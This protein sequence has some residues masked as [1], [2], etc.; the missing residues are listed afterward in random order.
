MKKFG[1]FFASAL[2]AFS[3]FIH[4]VFA[5]ESD[6]TIYFFGRNDCA[7]C[8]EEKAF[9][10]EYLPTVQGVTYEYFN[11][12]E[13]DTAKALYEK[14]LAKHELSHVTPVTVIGDMVLQGFDTKETTGETMKSAVARARAS[15]IRSLDDH[16]ARA[17]KQSDSFKGAGCDENGTECGTLTNPNMYMFNLPVIGVVDFKSFSLVSLSAVLGTIDGFNPCAMWVLITFLVLLT[18]VG[19]RKKMIFVAGLFIVAEAIMYNLI[20]NV[21]FTTWDFVGL[22]AVVTPLVGFLALGGGAFFLYRW[23][24]NRFKPLICDVSDL[25]TQGKTIAKIQKIIEQPTTIITVLAV[26]A[27][28]FSVNI[29]EF[30]CSIGIPQAYTKILELNDLSFISRQFYILIYTLGYMVDDL[31]VFGLAI[32]G[33]SRLESHGHK[34]SQLSLLIGGFLMLLLGAILI[35]DPAIFV[36]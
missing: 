32:W 27:I 28:A 2:F 18:Q 5:Q 31:I 24:K 35:I 11:V 22:D 7:H 33:F 9:L 13:D 10:A 3:A 21:W 4:P 26:I 17:P 14:V 1:L 23:H 30:A 36:L 29:I 16:L 8:A 19:D 25:E 34:Y 15:D 6:V 20:L 12:T